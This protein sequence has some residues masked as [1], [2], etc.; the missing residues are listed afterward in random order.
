MNKIK[1]LHVGVPPKNGGIQTYV[2]NLSKFIDKEKFEFHFIN[3]YDQIGFQKELIAMGDH[4]HKIPSRKE[5]MI[6]NQ[7]KLMEVIERENIDV[8]HN[9]Q[10]TLSYSN[11]IF[12]PQKY[13]RNTAVIVHSHC[14]YNITS[15]I[16]S[17]LHKYNQR[18]L[19]TWLDD[20]NEKICEL[21]CSIPAGKYMFD[22]DEFSVVK[23]AI[24]I[25]KYKFSLDVRREYR[26]KYNLDNF[27]VIGTVGRMSLQKN[28][29]FSVKIAKILKEKN[30]NFK[31][32]FI[33]DGPERGKIEQQILKW[34]LSDS[35]LM[36]GNRDDVDRWLN[37]FDVFI[38]PS[39]FEGLGISAIEAQCNGCPV[40]SSEHVPNEAI[41]LN[42]SCRV[43]LDNID[44]WISEI[45]NA[46]RIENASSLVRREGYDIYDSVNK[47]KSI[48]LSLREDLH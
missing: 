48:Y 6:L 5:N 18:K 32:I 15:H 9:H 8:I 27:L 24:D 1:V 2:Y 35:I 44:E 28:Y 37:V 11:G 38:F 19:N 10:S 23:N 21:S 36:L 25:D 39:I 12:L 13:R 45:L 41:L 17:V 22:N 34:N 3:W 4:V 33:G 26:K 42:N 29:L 40:I 16:T 46:H 43:N 7:K 14:E 20:G 31:M 30:V 47:M